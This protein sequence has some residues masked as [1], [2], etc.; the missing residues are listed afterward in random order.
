MIKRFALFFIFAAPVACFAAP[1]DGVYKQT[2]N[3]ECALVGVDGGALEIKDGIFHGVEVECRMTNPVNVLDMDAI[4]YTMQCSGED[5]NWT[6]RAMLMEPA[7]GEGLIM[8]W[9]GYAFVYDKCDA[10]TE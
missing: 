8:V 4:L 5:Q 7:E 9:N 2:A 10:Q 3:A 1:F 6:E